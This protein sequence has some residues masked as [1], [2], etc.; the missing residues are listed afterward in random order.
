MGS[1]CKTKNRAVRGGRS[2][3][4]EPRGKGWGPCPVLSNQKRVLQGLH[5]LTWGLTENWR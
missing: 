3:A 2:E 5:N 1:G 4:L